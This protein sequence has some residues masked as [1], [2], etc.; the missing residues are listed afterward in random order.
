MIEGKASLCLVELEAVD[1]DRVST[2]KSRLYRLQ[3]VQLV[4]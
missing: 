2:Y 1:K 4:Q 3:N